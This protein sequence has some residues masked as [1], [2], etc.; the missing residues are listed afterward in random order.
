MKIL[1]V[2][3]LSYLSVHTLC[4]CDQQITNLLPEG[5]LIGFV[6][7]EYDPAV[8]KSGTDVTIDDGTVI[9]S[10]K[11]DSLGRWSF[12]NLKTGTYNLSFAKDGYV[13]VID[14]GYSFVAGTVPAIHPGD[15]LSKFPDFKITEASVNF[16]WSESFLFDTQV[17]EIDTSVEIDTSDYGND[18]LELRLFAGLDSLVSFENY[19]FTAGI[20]SDGLA[21]LPD[22]ALLD[23]TPGEELY[24][25]FYPSVLNERFYKDLDRGLRIYTTLNPEGASPIVSLVIPEK[26]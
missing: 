12:S 21:N 8:S 13:K 9:L 15:F 10:T 26:D 22:P 11:T 16:D 20:F 2:I 4:S 1:K 7:L 17:P 14:Q 3:F 6:T 23:L 24:F 18:F 5:E 19:L 25:I